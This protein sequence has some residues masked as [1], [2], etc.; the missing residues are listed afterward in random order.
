MELTKIEKIQKRLRT[1]RNYLGKSQDEMGVITGKGLY[2]GNIE[3]GGDNP[4]DMALIQIA[5]KLGIDPNW[6]L[7]GTGESPIPEKDASKI[8][9]IVMP[10]VEKKEPK[11]VPITELPTGPKPIVSEDQPKQKNKNMKTPKLG[12][13]I[14]WRGELAKIVCEV[15]SN[16]VDVEMIHPD[17]CPHCGGELLPKFFNVIPTSPLFQECAEPV[18][19]MSE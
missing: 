1:Y 6:L 18:Q 2:Y 14:L 5:E 11:R 13:Y 4:S 17:K 16:S 19:T 7:D 10:L 3:R 9:E 12:D 15:R 8:P